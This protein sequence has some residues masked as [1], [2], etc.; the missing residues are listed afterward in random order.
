MARVSRQQKDALLAPS[1]R[2][3]RPSDPATRRSR[4]SPRTGARVL[5]AG[6]VS[7]AERAPCRVYAKQGD[8]ETRTA[9]LVGSAT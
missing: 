7:G 9:A 2:A 6:V 5:T 8:G 4:L 3:L 1:S